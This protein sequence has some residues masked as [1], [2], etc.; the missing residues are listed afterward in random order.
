MEVRYP[1]E[2][3]AA[4]DPELLDLLQQNDSRLAKIRAANE[5]QAKSVTLVVEGQSQKTDAASLVNFLKAALPAIT[6]PETKL[7]M[8]K[9]DYDAGFQWILQPPKAPAP[10]PGEKPNDN[11]TPEEPERPTLRHKSEN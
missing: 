8:A 11:K 10:P 9:V 3:R 4:G 1:P 7:M 5:I 2:N 6:A